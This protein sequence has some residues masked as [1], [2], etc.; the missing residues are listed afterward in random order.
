MATSCPMC[1][2]LLA[3]L[4]DQRNTSL[5][6]RSSHNPTYTVLGLTRSASNGCSTC[7][8]LFTKS[9]MTVYYPYTRVDVIQFNLS[10]KWDYS[11]S[12]N[13]ACQTND[14]PSSSKHSFLR[15]DISRG[16]SPFLVEFSSIHPHAVLFSRNHGLT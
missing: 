2:T 14:I 16:Q 15:L 13:R 3:L 11:Y 8:L 4:E 6:D 12:P 7:T 5:P 9:S 10:R 1:E